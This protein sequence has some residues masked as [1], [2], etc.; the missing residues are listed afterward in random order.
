MPRP[1]SQEAIESFREELCACASRLFAEHGI[2]AVTMRGLAAELGVSPMTPYRYFENKEEIFR[3]VRR[4]AFERFGDHLEAAAAG[5]AHPIDRFRALCRAYVAFALERPQDYRVMFQLDQGDSSDPDG[6]DGER[7]WE[8]LH[9][10]MERAVERG[11]LIGDPVDLAHVAWF[12]V[13]GAVTLQLAGKLN[14]GR[15]LEEMLDPARELLIAGASP[16]SI[17]ESAP[18]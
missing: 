3:A 18:R 16:R 14:M 5:I 11:L 9:D 12:S 1:L 15:T 10:T 7:A 2:A 8:V 4:A 6:L 17:S 13:H